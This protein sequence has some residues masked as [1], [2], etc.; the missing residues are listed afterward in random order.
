M[1]IT[2]NNISHVFRSKT[3]KKSLIKKKHIIDLMCDTSDMCSPDGEALTAYQ[4]GNKISDL[5]REHGH[6]YTY[7]TSV[8]L[9][10]LQ[11]SVYK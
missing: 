7:I 9:F 4:L 5:V 10:Q 1:K 2:T 3:R 8:G 6:V 11:L